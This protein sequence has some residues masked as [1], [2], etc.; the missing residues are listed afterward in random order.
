MDDITTQETKATRL[1][2]L[3]RLRVE[4][5]LRGIS[6]IELGDAFGVRRE[7]I[8]RDRQA[9][10]KADELY[11]QV[12]AKLPWNDTYTVAETAEKL[13]CS[14]STIRGMIRAGI[15]QATDWSNGDRPHYLVPLS[16]IRRL[17]R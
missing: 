4:K 17:Q 2:V 1:M 15:L 12:S 6:D 13:N 5:R 14:E 9:L 8:W 10:T 11:A 16:E 3:Y 7:T